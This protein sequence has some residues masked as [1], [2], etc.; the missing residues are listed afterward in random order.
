MAHNYYS[1]G[2]LVRDVVQGNTSIRAG[3]FAAVSVE[4]DENGLWVSVNSGN[5]NIALPFYGTDYETILT[6]K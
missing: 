2:K 5:K 4:V 1:T 3:D 6:S